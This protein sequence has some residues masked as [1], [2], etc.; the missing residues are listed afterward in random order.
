MTWTPGQKAVI[1]RERVVTIDRVTPS[2]RAIVGDRTFEVDGIERC[3]SYPRD[4]LAPLTPDIQAEMD[5]V[6]RGR[7]VNEC[8]F[9]AIDD[10][11]RWRR[12]AFTSRGHWAVPTAEDVDRAWRLVDAIREILPTK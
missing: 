10:A 7:V 3:K 12:Q 1:N 9:R 11:E 2:G 8:A 6:T 5:L 4:R